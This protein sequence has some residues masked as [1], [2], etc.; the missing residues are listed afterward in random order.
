[1]MHAKH[2]ERLAQWALGAVIGAAMGVV[3]G[4]LTVQSSLDT[5]WSGVTIGARIG[6]YMGW[7]GS[8]IV[9][10]LN[11]RGRFRMNYPLHGLLLGAASGG[12][13]FGG[14]GFFLAG[15]ELVLS[16]YSGFVDWFILSELLLLVAGGIF[17]GGL[18][19]IILSGILSLFKFIGMQV[20][21]SGH[22]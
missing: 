11:Y 5:N 20:S 14:Y 12:L 1:M 3:I 9:S 17:L 13:M 15:F 21:Y 8:L 6:A 4:V 7:A 10:L 2:K 19:G 16:I 18:W 22:S